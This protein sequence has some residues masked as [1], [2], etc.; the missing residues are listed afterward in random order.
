MGK[1]RIFEVRVAF[2]IK[3]PQSSGLGMTKSMTEEK[4]NRTGVDRRTGSPPPPAPAKPGTA[5]VVGLKGESTISSGLVCEGLIEEAEEVEGDSL[6][7]SGRDG[8]VERAV[9]IEPSGH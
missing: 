1:P 5:G 7:V 9:A 2:V 8:N 6:G 4:S 3:C